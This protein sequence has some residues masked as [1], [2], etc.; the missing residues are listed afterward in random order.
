MTTLPP[1]AD[2][3]AVVATH[4]RLGEAVCARIHQAATRLGVDLGPNPAWPA[5][6][7]R[8]QTD[9]YSGEISLIGT[10]KDGQRYGTITIF[11]TCASSLNTRY[12]SRIPNSPASSSRRCKSGAASINSRATLCCSPCRS[13]HERYLPAPPHPPAAQTENQ[14]PPALPAPARRHALFRAPA[15]REHPFSSETPHAAAIHPAGFLRQTEEKLELPPDSIEAVTDFHCWASGPDGDIPILL[16]GFTGIDPPFAAAEALGGKFIN[17][18]E[19]R[20]I[21]AIELDL[22]RRAY[23]HVLG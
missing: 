6:S 23:E 12:S 4:T 2:L 17:I 3:A 5:P 13:R 18:T 1:E 19:A 22:M 9:P 20:G 14:W 7:Y 10:W 21:V 16:G 8:Q 11:P 15:R